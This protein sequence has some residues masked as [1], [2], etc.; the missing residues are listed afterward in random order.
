MKQ[1]GIGGFLGAIVFFMW[2]FIFWS[3][4][5]ISSMI[6]DKVPEEEKLAGQLKQ[7]ISQAGTYFLPDPDLMVSNPEEFARRHEAG[8]VATIF[9]DPQG[10]PVMPPSVFLLGFLN[11]LVS[12]LFM[13]CLLQKAAPVLKSYASRLGFVMT[14]GFIGIVLS[15]LGPP[16][17]Y[18]FPW[19]LWTATAIFH[20]TGWLFVGLVLA[21]F[22][23]A[24]A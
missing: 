18:S 14:A 9:I 7:S 2:G 22:V 3:L 11:M 4:L 23:R 17:W 8:P 15:D 13:G 10:L 21:K 20:I 12:T 19:S 5:P 24:Q 6:F 1:V 16:I